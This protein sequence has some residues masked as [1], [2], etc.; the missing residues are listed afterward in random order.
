MW[1][2]SL[3]NQP[4]GP[5]DEGTLRSLFASGVI[6]GNTLIW[7]EGMPGW[8]MLWQTQIGP[9]MPA[10][11]AVPPVN[12]FYYQQPTKPSRK[13]LK[14]LFIWWLV[15]NCAY[16]VI[17]VAGALTN[18]LMENM[19]ETFLMLMA[20][21]N[22]VFYLPLMTSAVLEY[23]LLYK[24]WQNI[25]DGFASTTPGKAVGFMFIPFFNF[26]WMFRVFWGLAKDLNRYIVHHFS[27]R[28]QISVRR[29][30]QWVSL[31][32]LIVT[33]GGLILYIVGMSFFGFSMAM[34]DYYSSAFSSMSDTS[35]LLPMTIFMLV[36][37]LSSW[38][39]STATLIDFYLTSDSILK[40]EETPAQAVEEIAT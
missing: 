13:G 36:Y 38:G 20:A 18:L 22:C 24:Y 32:Y 14:N 5:V 15:T 28:P 8:V 7:R 40:A 16:L 25:Q 2:Y 26:Y 12:S 34:S 29:S 23:I 37:S 11:T 19:E 6:N 21:I 33:F 17:L 35:I 27:D 31:T 1:Y 9:S 3:N 39:L 10:P 30:K 4:A